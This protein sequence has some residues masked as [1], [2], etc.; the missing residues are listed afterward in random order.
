MPIRR[1]LDAIANLG[2]A[3]R[4]LD[5]GATLYRQGERCN[6]FFFVIS[7]WITLTTLLENGNCQILD[8]VI[9]GALLGFPF[10]SG[11]PRRHSAMC[12]TP[13]RVVCYPEVRL[14]DA[15]VKN[16]ELAIVLCRQ[17][18][19][20]EWRAHDHL[21]N[22]GLRSAR[23]RIAH[24]LLELSIRLAGRPPRKGESFRIPLTQSHVGQAVGLTSVHVSR[25]LRSLREQG[26]LRFV[27]QDL[28]I[29]DPVALGRAAGFPDLAP[30]VA[31]TLNDTRLMN[32]DALPKAC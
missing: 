28:H 21:T 7:G 12:V 6:A 17:A 10:L 18:A 22:V 27:K 9:P 19:L 5:A 3:D 15:I 16:A 1:Q 24:L 11:L 32:F 26:I 20:D 13:V 30:D 25:T 4:V 14:D 2:G 29:L 8:F 23:E 31:T